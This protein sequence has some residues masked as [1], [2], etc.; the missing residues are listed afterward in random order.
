M[1]WAGVTS[2]NCMDFSLTPPLLLAPSNRPD[3]KNLTLYLSSLGQMAFEYRDQSH[4]LISLSF[5][6]LSLSH[7]HTEVNGWAEMKY[8]KWDKKG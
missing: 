7:T 6:T 1:C 5:T 4:K 3:V 2:H 8:T